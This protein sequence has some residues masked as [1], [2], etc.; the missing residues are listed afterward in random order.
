MAA[1]K[2]FSGTVP[3]MNG[4]TPTWRRGGR[5]R[6][7][8]IALSAL[9]LTGLTA[10]VA[11]PA[12]AAPTGHRYEHAVAVDTNA[13]RTHRDLVKLKWNGCLDSYAEAQAARM[14]RKQ[15][16]QHQALLPILNHCHLDLVGENIAVGYPTGRAAVVAWMH[17]PGHR[18]NILKKR[19]RLYGVGA[20]RDVHGTWWVSHVFGR[21]V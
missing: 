8:A 18:A 3:A 4:V 1:L 13:Q 19:Y 12:D 21:K 17:S 11:P 9:T 5:R 2:D 10:A 16:L 6:F 20:Y 14:A 7:A 15:S